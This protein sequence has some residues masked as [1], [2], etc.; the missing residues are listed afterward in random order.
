MALHIGTVGGILGSI[1]LVIGI[2]WSVVYI[3]FLMVDLLSYAT[4]VYSYFHEWAPEVPLLMIYFLP[5]PSTIPWSSLYLEFSIIL[6]A[7]L[8][9]TG[10]FNGAGFYGLYKIGGGVMGILGTFFSS[11]GNTLVGLLIIMGNLMPIIE[12]HFEF[13]YSIFAPFIHFLVFFISAPNWSMIRAGFIILGITF[14]LLGSAGISVREMTGRPS[15]STAGGV[16]S[17]IGA[18]FFIIG[19]IILPTFTNIISMNSLF[20]LYI[21][22]PIFLIVGFILTLVALILWAVVFY[23]SREM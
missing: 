9:V 5:Y 22:G 12:G 10:V 16:L 21:F 18:I 14:I 13:H 6:G 19:G 20:V 8:I 15:A 4:P 2:I 17:I 1:T 11:I 7:F 23:S 3:Q